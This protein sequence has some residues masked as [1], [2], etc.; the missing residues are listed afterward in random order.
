[1]AKKTGGKAKTEG[2]KLRKVGS[3]F[4]K[5]IEQGPNKGDRVRFQVAPSGKPFPI[6]VLRD[7]GK[8]ST[9]RDRP[10]LF[11]KTSKKKATK[12][13]HKGPVFE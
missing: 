9:L 8:D 6:R 13:R 2:G 12:T 4:T 11:K 5:T 7:K 1:M 3:T 10:G